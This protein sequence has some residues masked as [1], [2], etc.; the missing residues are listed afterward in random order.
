MDKWAL[1]AVGMLEF[2]GRFLAANKM[3]TFSCSSWQ[4]RLSSSWHHQVCSS[5]RWR[6][7]DSQKWAP[8]KNTIGCRGLLEKT[9]WNQWNL[10]STPNCVSP[11][12][13]KP[14]SC[15]WKWLAALDATTGL[16]F[17]RGLPQIVGPTLGNYVQHWVFAILT[18]QPTY[19]RNTPI[20]PLAWLLQSCHCC[21]RDT[22]KQMSH[23]AQSQSLIF[24]KFLIPKAPWRFD[25]QRLANSWHWELHAV[26]AQHGGWHLL[27]MGRI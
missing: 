6:Q 25:S 11:F 21:L 2:Y 26:H 18:S 7:H 24:P 5:Q 27:S 10:Q 8:Q 1:Y 15:R 23:D 17:P 9:I 20:Q 13:E 12:D 16:A 19:K 4:H 3:H 22:D 14:Q